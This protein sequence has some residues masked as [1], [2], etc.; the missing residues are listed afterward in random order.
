MSDAAR[1][2]ALYLA[3]KETRVADALAHV[4]LYPTSLDARDK[5]QQTPLH[6]ASSR[7]LRDLVSALLCAGASP[8]ATDKNN[9][10]PLHCAANFG[11]FEV[12]KK[13]LAC[14]ANARAV[15]EAGTSALHYLSRH[16][17]E[18]QPEVFRDVLIVMLEHG[19]DIDA[20]NTHGETPLHQAAARNKLANVKTLIEF[21]A[22]I[23]SKTA[24][25]GET[26][27][28]FAV[29]AGHVEV[30]KYLL[31]VGA[32]PW[33]R[34][35]YGDCFTVAKANGQAEVLKFLME[36][37]EMQSKKKQS[38]AI[39]LP[40]AETSTIL[41]STD[42]TA[43]IGP[44]GILPRSRRMRHLQ[45]IM[46]RNLKYKEPLRSATLPSITPALTVVEEEKDIDKHV[47]ETKDKDK[48][49]KEESHDGVFSE[50][51]SLAD[52]L[53]NT[54]FTLHLTPTSEHFYSSEIAVGTLHPTWRPI[55]FEH[56]PSDI[57]PGQCYQFYLKIW[58]YGSASHV[59]SVLLELSVDLNN[60]CYV[61]DKILGI[62]ALPK[63]LVIFQLVDGL[64]LIEATVDALVRISAL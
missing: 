43:G 25:Y 35:D 50:T 17:I 10:T 15:T 60:L 41:S 37:N 45:A 6:C 20:H 7:D 31:E 52:Q 34:G 3:I 30:V 23:D 42:K 12:C 13:L 22:E 16:E 29:R 18:D 40:P 62:Q 19:C 57:S 8:L 4:D 44:K 54:F 49:K 2:E 9:W 46:C 27:L 36:F 28:H 56:I 59:A 11:N 32:D 33:K 38:T 39:V 1:D 51:S 61:G 58:R 64:Y 53:H 47:Q 26:P 14:G 55:S 63:N 5:L 21:H 48:E 24:R